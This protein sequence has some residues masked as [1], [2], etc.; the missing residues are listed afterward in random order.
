MNLSLD[1]HPEAS[2][3]RKRERFDENDHVV[4]P[5]SSIPQ[6]ES[7]AGSTRNKLDVL[8]SDSS[9]PDTLEQV[10][11][12]AGYE[13]QFH[14]TAGQP[15]MMRGQA[16]IN[17]AQLI[18]HQAASGLLQS[19]TELS[20]EIN[21]AGQNILDRPI[22]KMM[23]HLLKTFFPTNKRCNLKDYASLG[24]KNPASGS[25]EQVV[26]NPRNVKPT[27]VVGGLSSTG[28]SI[29]KLDSPFTRVRRNGVSTEIAASA[30]SFWEEL[31]LGPAH[32]PKDVDAFCVCPKSKCIEEGVMGFLSMIKGAYQSCN[33]GT[34]DLGASLTDY[35]ERIVTVPMNARDPDKFLQDIAATCEGFGTKLPELGLQNG[36]TVFYVINPFKD[37]RYL[38]R[39][40]D[41]LSRLPNSYGMAREKW[42]PEKQD[43]FVMQ[44]VP[45]DLVWSPEF[46]VVPSPAEYRKLAFEVYNQCASFQSGQNLDLDFISAPAVC[47][48]KA[49]PKTIDFKL[50]SESSAP[51]MQSD[52]CVH[53]SY[54]WDTVSE[55]LVAIWTDNQGILSWRACYCLG[56]DSEKPWKPFFEVA[57]EIFE[58]SFDM[59]RPPNAPWHLFICKD[60]LML[61]HEKEGKYQSL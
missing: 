25:R 8:T 31:S 53:V 11:D 33:L 2:L 44:I 24:E 37:Q 34:H 38:P 12:T 26:L 59:L 15:F 7:P 21:Q 40:C 42:R 47:L 52:N 58:T 28:R 55:W 51:L 45:L 30:L 13:G 4:T 56:R 46:M 20:E 60:R 36:T 41:A 57:K 27:H 49:I 35:S 17:A 22:Q 50:A 43:D 9:K 5:S 29:F 3:K 18:A 14:G 32:E 48:A 23:T 54:A 19:E 1:S 16:L 39:L 61:K 10:K 6:V